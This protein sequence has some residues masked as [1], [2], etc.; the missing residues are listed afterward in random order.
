[1]IVYNTTFHAHKDQSER[2]VDWLRSDYVPAAI[3]DGRLSQ[4]RLTLVLNAEESDGLNYSLQFSAAD[5]DTL[6]AWYEETGDDL[7]AALT[8]RFGHSVAGFTTL[9]EEVEL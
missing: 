5:I 2:F 8:K 9:L 3:A 1:M 6:R 7:L 4:P